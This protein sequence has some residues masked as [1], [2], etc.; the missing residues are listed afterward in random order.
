MGKQRAKEGGGGEEDL[1]DKVKLLTSSSS[2]L[3]Q[4]SDSAPL[5]QIQ[6]DNM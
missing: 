4:G 5:A 1:A 3:L 2:S 6:V